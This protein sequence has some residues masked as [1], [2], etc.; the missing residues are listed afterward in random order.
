VSH[1]RE[2]FFLYMPLHNVFVTGIGGKVTNSK[3][4]GTHK[5]LATCDGN[6]C[7]LTLNDVLHVLGQPHNLISLG[8]W[9]KASGH[10]SEPLPLKLRYTVA[11]GH[12]VNNNSCEMDVRLY[13]ENTTYKD[14]NPM[15]G[16]FVGTQSTITWETWHQRFG[17]I[18][19]SGLQKLLD[20]SMVEGFDVN[21]NSPRPDCVAYM[22]AKQNVEKVSKRSTEPS[23]LTHIN[24]GE[25]MPSTPSME[26]NITL[27]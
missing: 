4:K 17:H 18:H 13:K 25:N 1:Q 19:C 14:P 2:A 20:R 23:E 27:Q 22:E 21:I 6:M 16:T 24:F 8:R 3:G 15:P 9:D 5:L 26:T 12:Q 11:K 10:Y 7:I